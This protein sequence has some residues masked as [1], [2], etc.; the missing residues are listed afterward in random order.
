MSLISA[1][2]EYLCSNYLRVK[3]PGSSIFAYKII[4]KKI[5]YKETIFT[6]YYIKRSLERCKVD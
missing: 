6:S 1:D 5:N 4:T 3:L 2:Y